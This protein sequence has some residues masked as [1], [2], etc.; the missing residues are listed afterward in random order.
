MKE[1]KKYTIEPTELQKRAVNNIVQQKMTG[2]INKGKALKDAGYSDS[3]SKVPS[4]VTKSKGF[5]QLM[6]EALPDEN[7]VSCLAEDIKSKPGERLGEMKLAFGLKGHTSD[8]VEMDVKSDREIDLL[9]R[10]IDGDNGDT[11]PE[12]NI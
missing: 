11:E 8:R 12:S 7:L 3:I 5:L 2:K 4:L 9:K 1:T 6:N 10:L